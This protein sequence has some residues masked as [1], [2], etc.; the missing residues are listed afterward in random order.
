[1]SDDNNILDRLN[2]AQ[3]GN[4]HEDDGTPVPIRIDREPRETVEEALRRAEEEERHGRDIV[5]EYHEKYYGDSE[6]AKRRS[7]AE[8]LAG[9]RGRVSEMFASVDW[10]PR[11]FPVDGLS[12]DERLWSALA[13]GSFILTFLAGMMTEGWGGLLMV[14]VPLAIYFSF[15]DKSEFVAFHALQAFAAQLIGTVGWVAMLVTGVIILSLAIAISAVASVVLI[16]IPFLILF[17]I[18]LIVFVLGMILVPFG[19]AILSLIGA[20]NT[21]GGRDYRYPVIAKWIDRQT[22]HESRYI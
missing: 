15:R 20:I 14:F 8:E 16:G 22:S 3:P 2:A 19:I 4:N 1:M 7:R 21:Y 17:I 11:S 9:E 6:T 5:E 10:T 12:D 13:H 18:L